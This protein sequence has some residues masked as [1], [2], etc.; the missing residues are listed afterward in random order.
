MKVI[1]KFDG[2]LSYQGKASKQIIYVVK[3]LRMSLLGLP[4]ITSLNL[5]AWLGA[6]E[7]DRYFEEFSSLFRGLGN[8]G[9]PYD[10]QLEPDAIPYAL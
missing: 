5:I 1:G 6:V 8:L 9:E 10:I 7:G 3:G 4:A 2:V